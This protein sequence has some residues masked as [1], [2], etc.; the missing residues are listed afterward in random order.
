MAVEARMATRSFV[1]RAHHAGKDVYIW[2]VN[3][4]AWMLVALSR[5]V[6]GLI[7]DKPEVARAVI[8]RR[9]QMSDSQRF[10][11]ALMIRMGASTQALEA[12]RTRCGRERARITP[13][14]SWYR[15]DQCLWGN[16]PYAALP[17][18]FRTLE[19]K[20]IAVMFGA[21]RDAI[22]RSYS[23]RLTAGLRLGPYEILSL[24]GAGGMGEVYRARD[25][26]LGREIAIK[27]L[28]EHLSQE[29]DARMRFEREAKAI[30]A[31]SHPNILSI[32]DV[33]NEN[34]IHYAVTELLEG[35]TL[36][37][38]LSYGRLPWSLAAEIGTALAE[39]LA[40]AH[41]KAIIHRDLKPSNVFLTSD[42][43]IKILDFGLSRFSHPQS[44]DSETATFDSTEPG[45]VMGTLGY[46]SPEQVRGLPAGSGS[47]IFSLGCVLYEMDVGPTCVS[48]AYS[49]RG[50]VLDFERLAV[51]GTVQKRGLP[52]ELER[53]VFHCLEKKPERRFRSA[54]DLAF[55]LKAALAS[56]SAPARPE[57]THTTNSIAV[58]PFANECG[59]SDTEY[60]SDGITE[61]I[62]NS[63]A[64]LAQVDVVPRSTVFRYKGRELD[65]QALGQKLNVRF[66]LT[67]RVIHRGDTLLVAPKWWTSS[68]DRNSGASATTAKCPTSSCLRRKS[69]GK[70]P[71]VCE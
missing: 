46:M 55:A 69:R 56:A 38:R 26:R 61:S 2:T 57:P 59:E 20:K 5:G 64:Q 1:R 62:I 44:S 41:S 25:V 11:V 15:F 49:G 63:L 53:L 60:L 50:F 65:P 17:T 9:A 70:S 14:D 36:K 30:A 58:L 27:V 6:D 33:G 21:A 13:R 67:G 32:F 39:G 28:P 45:I 40:A 71:K 31:L 47:D 66:V 54:S 3:D 10:L 8:E 52:Q 24:L 22:L 4:P 48:G 12:E 29:I 19:R 43:P 23:M 7:T 35:E 68:R 37:S 34:G 18:M 16:S 42:G 51:N